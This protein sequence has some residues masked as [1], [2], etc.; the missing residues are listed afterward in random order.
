MF[1]CISLNVVTKEEEKK[2]Q[3]LSTFAQ[4]NEYIYIVKMKTIYLLFFFEITH[5][6]ISIV[7]IATSWH[8]VCGFLLRIIGKHHE[9]GNIFFFFCI[10]FVCWIFFCRLFFYLI[11]SFAVF[12]SEICCVESCFAGTYSNFHSKIKHWLIFTQK[13]ETTIF[14]FVLFCF[15]LLLF[16]FFRSIKWMTPKFARDQF[17]SNFRFSWMSSLQV[18]TLSFVVFFFDWNFLSIFA[19]IFFSVLFSSPFTFSEFFLLIF[20]SVAFHKISIFLYYLLI[21]RIIIT[22]F[23]VVVA[24]VIRLISDSSPRFTQRNVTTANF[25]FK[26]TE[27]NWLRGFEYNMRQ[28]TVWRFSKKIKKCFVY[29]FRFDW[30]VW[31]TRERTNKQKNAL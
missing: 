28:T 2:E 16:F 18:F 23:V 20:F 21:K 9:N 22:I 31:P 11:R 7:N 19:W 4:T 14:V 17:E 15:L 6:L 13:F 27:L 25:L 5:T 24:V 12:P 1:I 29:L 26:L 30:K 10:S 3:I 8:P